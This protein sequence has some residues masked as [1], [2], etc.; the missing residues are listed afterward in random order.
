MSGM[1]PR[2]RPYTTLITYHLAAGNIASARQLAAEFEREVNEGAQRADPWRHRALG[3]LALAS[4]DTAAAVRHFR[5]WTA[6]HPG[7]CSTVCGFFELATTYDL[8]GQSDSALA[9]YQRLADAPP[10]LLNVTTERSAL[11]PTYLRLGELYESRGETASAVRYYGDY[12]D[13][14]KGADPELQPL[15]SE[16][17][18]RLAG[19][20]GERR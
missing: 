14:R 11:A 5:E 4:G 13:L 10:G 7:N 3:Q 16:V 1:D 9:W 17:R 18:A 12:V 6:D 15:V 20:V 8:W 2:D 19:L